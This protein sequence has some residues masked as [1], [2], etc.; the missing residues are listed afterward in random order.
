MGDGRDNKLDHVRDN[1][2]P[3][4]QDNL[5]EA[6]MGAAPIKVAYNDAPAGLPSCNEILAT[7]QQMGYNNQQMLHKMDE[8]VGGSLKTQGVSL[9]QLNDMQARGNFNAGEKRALDIMI[10]GFNKASGEDGNASRMTLTEFAHYLIKSA[11]E[12]KCQFPGM[13]QPQQPNNGNNG[14]RRRM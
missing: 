12:E 1:S 9:A 2:T 11:V 5:G 13:N 8:F 7:T 3:S 4:G 6:R 14:M 10:K